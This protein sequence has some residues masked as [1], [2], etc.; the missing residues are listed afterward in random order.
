M[1]VITH[2][3]DETKILP[4]EKD[5]EMLSKQSLFGCYHEHRADHH[6]VNNKGFN[7]NIRPALE[8]KFKPDIEHLLSENRENN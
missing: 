5:N 4:V 3:P 6:A 2:S 7:R 8:R 1:S